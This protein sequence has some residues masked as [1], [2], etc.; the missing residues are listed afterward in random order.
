MPFTL[1]WSPSHL[2]PPPFV[3]PVRAVANTEAF[4]RKWAS[5][6]T[7]RGPYRDAVVRSLV[8]LKALT[9]AP[10]GGLVAAPTAVANA[11]NGRPEHGL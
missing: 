1:T 5:R 11:S 8:T 6:S 7:Y 2:T 9:Y 3:D 4:W 10:T